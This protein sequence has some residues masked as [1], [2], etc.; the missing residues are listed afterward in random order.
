MK[1]KRD[2]TVG[3]VGGMGPHSGCDL[4]EKILSNSSAK[5]DQEYISVVLMSFPSSHV[6]RTSFLLGET[7]INPAYSIVDVIRKLEVS[8]AEIV[9]IS[10]NTAY[11]PRIFNVIQNELKRVKCNIKLLSMPFETCMKIK[12]EHSNI[13]RVGIMATNGTYKSEIYK[14]QLVDL[15]L[16]PITPDFEFQN[17]IIHAMIYDP[18]YGI[19]SN[20]EHIHAKAKVLVKKAIEYFKNQGAEAIILGC[21]ELS[22]I[23][24]E[25]NIK[26]MEIIDSTQEFSR[27]LIK[28]AKVALQNPKELSFLTN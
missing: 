7:S 15:G 13:T 9:G 18:E 19:K 10:C 12:R 4:F 5:T 28:E 16:E 3:I 25:K 23:I 8:G 21:T 26:G 2:K 24:K 22:L 27:A 14:K 17:E 20:P 1:I 11:S 6:D